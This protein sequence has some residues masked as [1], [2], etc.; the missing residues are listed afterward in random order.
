VSLANPPG[1]GVADDKSMYCNVPD[2]IA[3]YLGER[4]L[5]DPTPTYRCADPIERSSVLD[6]LDRLV[7]KPVDGYGGGGVLIGPRADA[8]EIERRRKEIIADPALWIAQEMVN[9]STHPTLT[10]DGMQPRHVDLRAFVYLTGTG[11]SDAVVADLG[12]TRVAPEG[13]MLV[14]SSR[15]G[16]AKDTWIL[17]DPPEES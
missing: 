12:L 8:D 15:G 6:R 7:T 10:R 14:N 11:E 16:G 3:Y 9:L 1:N 5:L 4:P 2:L 17:A 13:S